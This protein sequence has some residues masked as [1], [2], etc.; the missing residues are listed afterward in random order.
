M[1]V[2]N[3]ESFKVQVNRQNAHSRTLAARAIV[4]LFRLVKRE[5]EINRQILAFSISLDHRLVRIHGHY[6][7]IDGKNT[8]Y[9]RHPVR[10]FDCTELDGKE[11]WTAYQLTR[12]ISTL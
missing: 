3:I 10:T 9:Y 2:L 12:N 4:E 7:V 6:P 5:E 8:T 11:K 1:H